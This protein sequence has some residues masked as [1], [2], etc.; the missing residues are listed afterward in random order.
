MAIEAPWQPLTPT[1]LAS[2]PEASAAFEI[3]SL[4]RTV[5]FIGGDP[6][7]GLRS[8]VRRALSDPKLRLRAHCIRWEMT[9]DPRG[10]AGELVAAHRAAHAGATPAE[11]PR[12]V[13]SVRVFLPAPADPPS[14][15]TAAAAA[16][17]APAAVRFLRVRTVA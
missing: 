1:V 9:P 5:L 12:P 8:A 3:G 10:R 4:V 16:K 14:V 11:Q 15:P 17:R 6:G 7:E 13:P 2:L